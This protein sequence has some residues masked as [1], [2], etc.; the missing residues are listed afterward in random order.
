MSFTA[1]EDTPIEVDLVALARSTGWSV[2]NDIAT[3]ESCNNGSI[4]LTGY[5]IVEGKT[6]S[7]S[8]KVLSISGGYVQL[9]MGDNGGAQRTT[10]ASYTET[11]LATG[12]NPILSFYSNANCELQAFNI[13]EVVEDVGNTQQHTV[14]YSPVIRKWTSFYTM[15]PDFG[16][17]MFI[18]T[19]VFKYGILYSQQNGSDDRN[20]LFGTLYDSLF[21]FVENKNT[22]IVQTYE[23]LSIQGNQ[24]LITTND[25][26]ETSLGQLSTLIDSDFIQQSLTD[27]DIQVDIYDRYGVYMASFVGDNNSG[28]ELKGNYLIVQLQSTDSG[29]P[30]QFYTVNVRSSIQRVG[31]R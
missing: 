2:A 10:A 26:V 21:Q 6:Y 16:L 30:M 25:G 13:Q 29:N 22:A 3:H 11:L 8:Y 5:T 18:R 15:A 17:S 14:V 24:L 9:F 31:A 27:G 28:D 12:D 4:K 23:S 20:N 19:L 7:I 1:V